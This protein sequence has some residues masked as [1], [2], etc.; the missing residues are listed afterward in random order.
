MSVNARKCICTKILSKDRPHSSG[1]VCASG[2][3]VMDNL[4]EDF[5]Q[6]ELDFIGLRHNLIRFCRPAKSDRTGSI[7]RK[8]DAK[9][10]ERYDT[11]CSCAP[12]TVRVI[13][14]SLRS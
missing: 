8:S 10:A 5:S 12:C 14:G 4:V 11:L 6:L 7:L 13:H 2:E 3:C 1:S 9:R